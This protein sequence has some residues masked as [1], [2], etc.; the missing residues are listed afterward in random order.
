VIPVGSHAERHIQ[1]LRRRGRC[2]RQFL[3]SRDPD[4]L[5]TPRVSDD[6]HLLA[7]ELIRRRDARTVRNA[8]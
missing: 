3:R 6:A 4:S 5:F 7:S 8:I 2:S 1:D